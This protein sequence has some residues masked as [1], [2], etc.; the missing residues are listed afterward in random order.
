MLSIPPAA[1]TDRSPS[2]MLCAARMMD[3]KPLAHTLLI[4]VASELVWRPAASA[5]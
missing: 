3:F 4:V 5:T 2:L 1:T